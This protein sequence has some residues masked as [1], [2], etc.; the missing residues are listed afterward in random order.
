VVAVDQ[1]FKRR[2]YSYDVAANCLLTDYHLS[3]KPIT[4]QMTFGEVFVWL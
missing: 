4:S 1:N 3:D 2:R